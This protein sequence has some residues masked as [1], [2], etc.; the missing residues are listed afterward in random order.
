MHFCWFSTGIIFCGKRSSLDKVRVVD[1]SGELQYGNTVGS[2]PLLVSQCFFSR[3]E[4]IISFYPI[5][6]LKFQY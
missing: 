2:I 3:F 4:E 6:T 1:P 5:T